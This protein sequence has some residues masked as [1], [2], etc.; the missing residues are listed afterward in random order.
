MGKE[1]HE[2]LV[3]FLKTLHDSKGWG[4]DASL[5]DSNYV[6]AAFSLTKATLKQRTV[7]FDCGC[8]HKFLMTSFSLKDCL[9]GAKAWYFPYSPFWSTGQRRA[10]ASLPP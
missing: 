9:R 4:S 1:M 8:L 7:T 10:I 6:S 2:A 3:F 5:R